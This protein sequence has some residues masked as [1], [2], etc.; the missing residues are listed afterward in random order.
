MTPLGRSGLTVSEVCLGT[1]TFGEQNSR[2]DAFA[3][4]DLAQDRG[5]NFLDT[6]ELYA[7]PPRAETH[8]RTEEYI[9][10]WFAARGN[11]DRW[12]VASKV[13]GRSSM[14]WF[15]PWEGETRVD[16]RNIRY[17]IEGSLKRLKTDRIDLYQIHWPDR[18]M[19]IFGAVGYDHQPGDA[20][21]I[22]EQLAILKALV[23]EGKIR[24]VGL[25]NETPWGVMRFL[26]AADRL[27][28]PR[29]A[30]VQNAYSLLNRVDDT[31]LAEV[32]IREEV[33]YLPYSP[34]G[35]GVLTGK[36]LGGARPEGSRKVLFDRLQRYETEGVETVIRAYCDLA[37]AAGLTPAQMALAFVRQRPFVTSTIIGATTLP[38]LQ[39][40]LSAF[41][42]TLS[43]DVLKGI[44][45]IHRLRPNPC[46]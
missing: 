13:V 12:I 44:E 16:E 24:A 4:L 19:K 1:M 15:R 37:Q 27:G 2:E 20:V 30:S 3:Q 40:N 8:G 36:Y 9:G 38:Q 22:E 33:G 31:A 25:S 6:A 42:V 43:A 14:D 45:A 35:Q 11:R 28:L 26:E 23:D 34:L 17:A 39:E 10:D 7:I 18:P 41:D 29:V 5:I 46:P 32:L 21:P